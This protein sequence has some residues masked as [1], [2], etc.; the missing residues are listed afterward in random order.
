M[1]THMKTTVE[2]SDSLLA[3][4]KRLAASRRTTV[5]ALIEQA[6]RELVRQRASAPP[7]RLRPA[8]FKGKGMPP[9]VR[10]GSWEQVRDL[11]YEGRGG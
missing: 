6:L 3:Q 2:I 1:V 9:T 11:I 5:R 8:S 4:V 10:E 7:F